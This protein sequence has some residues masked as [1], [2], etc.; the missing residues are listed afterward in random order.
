MLQHRGP[1]R[2]AIAHLRSAV[3]L[4]GCYSNLLSNIQV[5][6][7]ITLGIVQSATLLLAQVASQH[8]TATDHRCN[9]QLQRLASAQVRRDGAA[10]AA[11]EMICAGASRA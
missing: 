11:V 3:G 4:P 2:A 7:T 10:S 5:H 1:L 9:Q 6:A 8:R